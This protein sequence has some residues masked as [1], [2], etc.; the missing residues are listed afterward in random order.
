MSATYAPELLH[1][2]VERA[3]RADFPAFEAQLRSTGGCARRVRLRGTIET[4]DGHGHKRVWS[5]DSQP[6]GV[7]LKACGNRR[8]AVCPPC[9]ERYRGDAYQ[10]IVSGLRGGKGLP[11]SVAEHPAIFATLTVPS[12]GPV[13]TR[14]PGS[15]GTSRRCRPRRDDPICPHGRRLSCGAIHDEGDPVLGDPLCPGCFD[16]HAAATWNNSLGALWRYTTIAIPRARR[17]ASG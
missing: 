11:G 14:V 17:A 10:L 2:L 9:A 6:D 3:G 4:C 8:E 7:L 13:H 16:H 5:T 1:G 12:F 15:D